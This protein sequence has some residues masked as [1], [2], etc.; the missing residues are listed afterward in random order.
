[1]TDFDR[2]DHHKYGLIQVRPGVYEK[3]HD[4]CCKSGGPVDWAVYYR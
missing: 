1:M 3:C 2:L 4:R